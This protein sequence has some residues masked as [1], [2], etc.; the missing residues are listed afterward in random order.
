MTVEQAKRER[1]LLESRMTKM[2]QMFEKKTGAR[3]RDVSFSETYLSTS[4]DLRSPSY[5]AGRNISVDAVL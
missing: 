1:T 5:Y 4:M 2:V 3:V